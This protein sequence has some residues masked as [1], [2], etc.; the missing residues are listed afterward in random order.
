MMIQNTKSPARM[1]CAFTP[2]RSTTIAA[3]LALA[4]LCLALSSCDRRMQSGNSAAPT[5]TNSTAHPGATSTVPA[6]MAQTGIGGKPQTAA[7]SNAVQ[8]EIDQFGD[9]LNIVAQIK[10]GGIPEG[11][12]LLAAVKHL[13]QDQ[14]ADIAHDL[15]MKNKG[16]LSPA[17]YLCTNALAVQTDQDAVNNLCF[18]TGV[19]YEKLGK[20]EPDSGTRATYYDQAISF[21]KA[22]L[23]RVAQGASQV[24]AANTAFYLADV[25]QRTKQY[26]LAEHYYNTF[27]DYSES[28][29]HSHNNA[30]FARLQLA[31]MLAFVD[32]A[33]AEAMCNTLLADEPTTLHRQDIE[34]ILRVYIPQGRSQLA[35]EPSTTMKK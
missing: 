6:A 22:V 1:D 20:N 19:A 29:E 25:Y 18:L 31:Q 7:Q 35:T 15:I 28:I 9:A 33:R 27:A 5:T 24:A 11:S 10:Q 2:L 4:A 26:A 3:T 23:D 34:R 30:V 14:I 8:A 32:P 13:P 16:A 12:E 21:Y 17:I